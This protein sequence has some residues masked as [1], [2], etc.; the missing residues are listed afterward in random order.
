MSIMMMERHKLHVLA[1]IALTV[2]L[3]TILNLHFGKIRLVLQS[4]AGGI[5]PS[6]QSDTKGRMQ[7]LSEKI[8]PD[9]LLNAAHDL[10]KAG[11]SL[12]FV[13]HGTFFTESQ[14][15]FLQAAALEEQSVHLARPAKNTRGAMRTSLSKTS[16]AD[17]SA[18]YS[19]QST[20]ASGFPIA[21]QLARSLPAPNHHPPAAPPRP[22]TCAPPPPGAR[23]S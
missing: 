9:M 16:N 10:E 13:L 4:K 15:L 1:I 8:T 5:H 6:F 3:G 17:D 20:L 11:G 22:A 12:R 18:A 19:P 21:Q 14:L 7:S 23:S 2:I